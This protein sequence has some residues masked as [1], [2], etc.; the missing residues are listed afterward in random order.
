MLLVADAVERKLLP[1]LTFKRFLLLL[2]ALMFKLLLL[3]LL[4]LPPVV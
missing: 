3:L 2:P 1:V 4:L